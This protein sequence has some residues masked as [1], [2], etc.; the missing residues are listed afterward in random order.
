MQYRLYRFTFAKA[1]YAVVPTSKTELIR[2]LMEN[3][4]YG[5]FRYTAENLE[6]H[7]TIVPM[8]YVT[9][10]CKALAELEDDGALYM[11]VECPWC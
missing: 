5:E 7:E 1:T 4:E 9:S 11:L 10:N 2:H 3:S 6:W 8:E